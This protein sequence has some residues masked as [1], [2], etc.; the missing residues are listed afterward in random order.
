MKEV[1]QEVELT[2]FRVI[3]MFRKHLNSANSL[4]VNAKNS[5]KVMAEYIEKNI[6]NHTSEEKN[7]WIGVK[8]VIDDL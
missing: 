4:N 1:S 8:N 2:A 5:A 6:V 7:F 3:Q